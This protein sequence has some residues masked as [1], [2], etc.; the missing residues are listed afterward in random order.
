MPKFMCTHTV[1]PNSITREQVEQIAEAAQNDPQVHGYRSYLNLSAGKAICIFEA[2]S[3]EAMSRW[4][5]KMKLPYDEITQ[6]ELEGDK[7]TISEAGQRPYVGQ[8]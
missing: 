8:A 5:Q 4:F 7:G 6:V 2:P 1:A 3:E